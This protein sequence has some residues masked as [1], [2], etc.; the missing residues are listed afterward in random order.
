MNDFEISLENPYFDVNGKQFPPVLPVL[1]I[2]GTVIY[3]TMVIP[4]LVAREKS[5]QMIKE[6][7][8]GDRMLGL[9]AQ[10]NPEDENPEPENIYSIGVVA[11]IVKMIKMPDNAIRIMIEAVCRIKATE[12]LSKEP[13]FTAQI[14]PI[15]EKVRKTKRLD[16][17]ALN[18]RELFKTLVSVSPNLPKELNMITHN[19]SDPGKLADIISS[20]LNLKLEER[21]NILE[22][23][24]VTK[25][26]QQLNILLNRELEIQ[27]LG[28]R[29]QDQMKDE[30][31]KSQKE[32]LIRQQMRALQKELGETDD[33]TVEIEDLSKKIEDAK[34]PE[35]VHQT[36]IKELD[37]LKRMPPSAAEYTV[38]R[39]YLDWLLE[40]PWN[41]S[42]EDTLD[43]RKVQKILDDDHFGL[44]KI[45]QRIVEYIAVRHLKSDMKGPI[46]CFVGPPGT[47]KTSLGKSIARAMNR[48]FHRISVGGVKDEAEIRGHRRT[49]VGAL[50]G[51]IIQGLRKSGS[52]NPVFML[53]EVD[54]IGMDFRGDPAS[55]LLE[56]L[57]P[58]QNNS[59][60]DH[61]LD[62][63][64]DLSKVMFITT[65]NVLETIPPALRDR[66]EVLRL[67]GY[68]A[69]EK[70]EIAVRHLIPRQ[71]FEHGLTKKHLRFHTKSIT[72]IVR[73]YTHEAG[74]RNLEREISKICRATAREVV[75]GRT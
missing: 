30:M 4:L 36:A 33:R 35:E 60:V 24:S 57:D 62:V 2:R 21:Q 6:V 48:K 8:E 66:M 23:F 70:T 51:R 73:E 58:E 65:A 17:L 54:K 29:I 7:L 13:F 10:K 1:P 20:S 61:Y 34:F 68:T 42:T 67:S 74:V 16:A 22:I 52:N 50:P 69:E 25:R 15:V 47:G 40:L 43:T 63:N 18:V 64:F 5:V 41:S 14:E 49:Y 3:P 12:F 28:N 27:E 44:D 19:I 55:A 39:T 9:F 26:L 72:Q 11:Q 53:D 32:Y 38:S 59:F 31:D 56:V 45:K 71:L 46:L 75:E 37:R